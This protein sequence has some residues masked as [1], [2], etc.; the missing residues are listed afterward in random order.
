MANETMT[1][2]TKFTLS[3][4]DI[5]A[6][7]AEYLTRTQDRKVMPAEVSIDVHPGTPY[8]NQLDQGTKAT[9]KVSATIKQPAR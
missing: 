7:V 2:E 9:V 8:Y 3:E 1:M 4:G 6:A 5:K